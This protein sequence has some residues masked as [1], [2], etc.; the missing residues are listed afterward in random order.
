MGGVVM[1]YSEALDYLYGLINYEVQR[2]E[3]YTPSVIS[4]DRPR[5]LMALLGNPQETYP[6][7][8]ITGT[9]GKG[10]VS[11]QCASILKAAGLRVGLYSSPHLQDFRE[12][13]RVN[14]ALIEPETLVAIVEQVKPFVEQ[15]PG[16]T[17]FEVITAIAF[18]YFAQASVDVAVIEVGL[19]G[20]LDST[21]IIAAPRVS[22]ITSLSYDHQYLLGNTLAEIAFEKA[23]IIKPGFPVVSAPQHPEALEVI[24]RIAAERGSPLKVVGTDT[25]FE[26][27]QADSYGQ[28]F[29]VEGRNYWTP[30]IG[31]HQVINAATALAALN[32]VRHA[33]DLPISETAIHMGLAAVNWP[34][35]FELIRRADRAPIVLDV[36][37]NGESAERLA[38][39]LRTVFPDRKIT[40]IFGA[41]TDKD[42]AGMFHAL[43]PL[44]NQLVLMQAL[45]PRAYQ[46]DQLKELAVAAGYTGPMHTIPAAIEALAF[47][48]T[49]AMPNDVICVTGSVALVGEMRAVL[50]LPTAHAM[51]LDE[52]AV[53]AHQPNA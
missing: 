50:N 33:P 39:T 42:V 44:A 18:L 15:V 29:R 20:R 32:I 3:R 4:L 27:G 53:K 38:H 5:A 25:H 43:L 45:N 40:F 2:V 16:L 36:A 19:G 10:S 46:T 13:F 41:F 48:D 30:L 11:A 21:N 51:Y 52:N 6:I 34:G 31:E 28:D 22:V 17:W 26:S 23:G 12:R 24:Q 1:D 14:D 35:R 37:H 47:S 49:I 8:H 7:L 9:K